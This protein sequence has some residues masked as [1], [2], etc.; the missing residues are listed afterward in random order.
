MQRE[1]HA[2]IVCNGCRLW[3]EFA[4][5]RNAS[6]VA[7]AACVVCPLRSLSLLHPLL[8][9]VCAA[10]A[11]LFPPRLR[12]ASEQILLRRVVIRQSNRQRTMTAVHKQ[13]QQRRS[14]VAV[15]PL[16]VAGLVALLWPALPSVSAAAGG[17]GSASTYS[18]P[19]PSSLVSVSSFQRAKYALS[20]SGA[21]VLLA[22][23]ASQ[24]QGW[25]WP[26]AT[27]S[28]EPMEPIT[29]DV[30]HRKPI[31]EGNPVL[32]PPEPPMTLPSLTP[33][34]GQIAVDPSTG[35]L[36]AISTSAYSL[37]QFKPLSGGLLGY[38]AG[39]WVD[40]VAAELGPA[41]AVKLHTL[42]GKDSVIVWALPVDA[43]PTADHLPSLALINSTGQIQWNQSHPITTE[44]CVAH[45]DFLDLMLQNDGTLAATMLYAQCGSD[46]A[47]V[48]AMTGEILWQKAHDTSSDPAGWFAKM[49]SVSAQTGDLFF[50]SDATTN[51]IERLS[52][53]SPGDPLPWP[54]TET[55]KNPPDVPD[56]DLQL[57]SVE[58]LED[59]SSCATLAA[60]CTD[61]QYVHVYEAIP[62]NDNVLRAYMT[63]F[64]AQATAPMPLWDTSAFFQP[65][66]GSHS[67][68]YPVQMRTGRLVL[69]LVRSQHPTGS[70]FDLPMLYAVNATDGSLVR[71]FNLGLLALPE[72]SPGAS[73][74]P[75]SCEV[76]DVDSYSLGI[77]VLSC[78]KVFGKI[79]VI[80]DWTVGQAVGSSTAAAAAAADSSTAAAAESSTAAWAAESS[81]AAFAS[82]TEGI[83]STG[84]FSSTGQAFGSSTGV[85]AAPE[86]LGGDSS[87]G[88][89][90]DA[91]SSSGVDSTLA[92]DV[93]PESDGSG[94][95]QSVVFVFVV[96]FVLLVSCAVLASLVHC[97]QARRG[98]SHAQHMRLSQT[99]GSP[100]GLGRGIHLDGSVDSEWDPEAQ[101]PHWPD[102][103]GR[104]QGTEMASRRVLTAE[105]RAALSEHDRAMLELEEAIGAGLAGGY[106]DDAHGGGDDDDEAEFRRAIG[107]DVPVTTKINSAPSSSSSYAQATAKNGSHKHKSASPDEDDLLDI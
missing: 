41:Q 52:H 17:S 101:D 73:S 48:N 9:A 23:N 37:L 42:A 7:V 16:L 6:H 70:D 50:A 61:L 11:S 78:P 35:T 26:S 103:G 65:A 58:V 57:M 68:P 30:Q 31:A 102:G 83:S 97:I 25:P 62:A 87:S 82:S 106:D 98:V 21:S 33:A 64:D 81:T 4:A 15:L 69:W 96:I 60:N 93:A 8:A 20:S 71:S 40:L 92:A 1:G 95:L 45:P 107:Q 5:P 89:R 84:D 94:F 22:S 34:A 43:D 19:L 39:F 86:G 3:S 12:A 49:H 99:G 91:S 47:A 36:F 63:A 55:R 2:W 67:Q 28:R 18:L 72:L 54:F 53:M 100:R 14:L 27:G 79:I 13:Q 51:T 80:Q 76:V 90:G 24:I 32:T 56:L 10:C 88:V 46:I 44:S 59:S 77:V 66:G 75:P 38:E 85:D 104:S 105:E 74:P 29:L